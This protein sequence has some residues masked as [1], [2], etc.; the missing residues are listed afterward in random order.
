MK[1]LTLS[2]N[3][4]FNGLTPAIALLSKPLSLACLLARAWLTGSP[5]MFRRVLMLKLL[6]AALA[7]PNCAKSN[8]K[9]KP[10]QLNKPDL[11]R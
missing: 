3:L 1:A 6:L 11:P 10:L 2:R 7:N 5:L 8:I 4:D 9:K